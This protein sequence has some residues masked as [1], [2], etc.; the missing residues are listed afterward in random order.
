MKHLQFLSVLAVSILLLSACRSTSNV[1]AEGDGD[2]DST[3]VYTN[4]VHVLVDGRDVGPIPQTIRVRRSFGTREIS[5]WKAGEEIRTYEIPISPTSE[6]DQT[7]MGFFGSSS[8]DGESYDVRT[9]PNK[10]ETYQVPYSDGPMK[11]E[12][13]QYGVTLLIR[14]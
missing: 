5:L 3:R 11:I 14:E 7:R 4:A 10:D 9:L 2:G 13:R 1:T 12:D 6:G 8:A